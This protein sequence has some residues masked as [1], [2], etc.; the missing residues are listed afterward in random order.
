VDA[1][2]KVEKDAARMTV[3]AAARSLGIKE[4]SVRKRVRRRKMRSEKGED[5]RLYMYVENSEHPV[6]ERY[7]DESRDTDRQLLKFKDETIRI[8]QAHL[9]EEQEARR[10]ADTVI[11]KLTHANGVLA[12]R[13]P[14]L[15]AS[16]AHEEATQVTA[17]GTISMERGGTGAPR[18]SMRPRDP[19]EFAVHGSLT[20]PWW[21]RVF[22]A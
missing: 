18:N 3:A 15:G 5:G 11:A 19:A 22:G 9:Q 4:E 21:R 8:L 1:S 10:R 14:E 17:E 16:Q 7:V 13:I 12:Q 20:R 6:A 2:R